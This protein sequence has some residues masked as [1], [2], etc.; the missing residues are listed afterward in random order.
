MDT[1]RVFT[2]VKEFGKGEKITFVDMD[3]EGFKSWYG[4][5]MGQVELSMPVMDG[6]VWYKHNHREYSFKNISKFGK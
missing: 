2:K 3:W 4:Y 6:S 1:I 5:G